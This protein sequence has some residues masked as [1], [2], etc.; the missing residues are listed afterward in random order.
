MQTAIVVERSEWESWTERIVHLELMAKT[1][2]NAPPNDAM[3]T[4]KEV[5]ERLN[6]TEE[7]VRRARRCGRLNGKKINE[8]EWGFPAYEVTRYLNRYKRNV[9]RLDKSPNV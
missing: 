6:I 7:G 4:V 8:K 3:L 1:L 5:A 9:P 2:K